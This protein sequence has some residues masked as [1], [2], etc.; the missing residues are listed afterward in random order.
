MIEGI[1]DVRGQG[2]E[3]QEMVDQGNVVYVLSVCVFDICEIVLLCAHDM[4]QTCFGCNYI[5]LLYY[6]ER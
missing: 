1:T 3:V 6:S 5:Y 2:V 4:S